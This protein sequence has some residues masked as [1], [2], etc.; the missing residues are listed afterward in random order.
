MAR[1]IRIEYPGAYYHVMARGNRREAIFLDDDD[2]RF[3]LQT[4]S[5]ACGRTGWRV[6][7]W[8]LMGNHYHLF[9]ETPE[10]NLSV[11]MKWLQNT[12]TRRFNVRHRKWGRVFGDRYKAVLVEGGSAHHYGTLLDYIHLNPV[13][14]R[15]IRPKD[16][17]SILDF[18]WSSLAGGYALPSGRRAKWLAAAA[19]LAA[20][21]VPD[22]AAGRRQ[23][24]ERLDRR[25]VMEERGRC[26]VPVMESEVDARCSHLRRGWYWGT[27]AFAERM[28]S[29]FR[30]DAAKAKSRAYSRTAER[31]AHGWQQAERWLREGLAA[32]GLSEADL[33]RLKGTDARKVALADLLWR[34]TTVSQS[35][36]AEKLHLQS[37]ANASQLLRR[38]APQ[39]L[40]N[41]RSLPAPLREFLKSAPLES[42][43]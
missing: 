36:L 27:Q 10:A 12:F 40:K 4:L 30:P 25:A 33:A 14:A 5:E 22:T 31:R 24:V 2:R 13:R 41:K 9:I 39:V 43:A 15:M 7:A 11:G 23:F 19:G 8:V 37:A 3:F 16:G 17:Q 35:W 34:H 32:A 18:P 28:L 29:N 1:S 42:C 26:G 38:T 6:H 20:A 21:G